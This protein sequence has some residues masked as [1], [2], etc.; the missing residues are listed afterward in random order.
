MPPLTGVFTE[1]ACLKS[2]STAA[3]SMCGAWNDYSLAYVRSLARL[4]Q[5]GYPALEIMASIEETC[6]VDM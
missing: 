5:A 2:A 3:I 4:C 1:H 6:R